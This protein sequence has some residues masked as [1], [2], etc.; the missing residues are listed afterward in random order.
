MTKKKKV[1]KEINEQELN[2]EI[3]VENESAENEEEN[4][5]T[6]ENLEEE[7]SPEVKLEKEVAELKEKYLRLY[8]DFEN[9]RKRTAKERIDMI[10]TASEE[11]LIDLL[12][13]VDDFERAFKA[14]EKEEDGSKVLEG[15]QIVFE[16]LLKILK[17]KGLTPMEDMIGK[18]FDADTQ[19]AITQIPAP[20]EDMKGMVIDVIEKGYTLGDKVV[21]FAKV[22]T[23][24]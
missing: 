1:E 16:K 24:A 15:N 23:G 12:P 3:L 9:F 14:N 11:V 7:V 8:S 5:Q 22:V 6:E 20:S 19:E 13:A 18:P 2:E 17:S 21:R 4:S 10:S